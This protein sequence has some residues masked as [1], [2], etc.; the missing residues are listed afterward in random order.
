MKPGGQL[1]AVEEDA[2]G[3]NDRSEIRAC[4]AANARITG[5]D[6]LSEGSELLRVVAIGAEG[7]AQLGCEGSWE[8]VGGR[9]GVRLGGV[10][11]GGWNWAM[12]VYALARKAEERERKLTRNCSLAKKLDRGDTLSV[13]GGLAQS[14][15]GEHR[16]GVG[17]RG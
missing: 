7:T 9:C 12:S 11:D 14:S 3:W 8:G 6:G 17:S 1:A 13:L 15:G 2:L 16:C 4:R 10:V 5:L